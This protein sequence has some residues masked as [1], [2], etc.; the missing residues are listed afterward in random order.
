L[1]TPN[2]GSRRIA[3]A[4]D[5]DQHPDI[6]PSTSKVPGT[7]PTVTRTSQPSQPS[8]VTAP[9]REQHLPDSRPAPAAKTSAA[10]VFALVFGLAALFCALTAILSPAAILFGII[11][12]ILAV[13]G[14]KMAKRPGITGKSV[15][16][17]GLVTA[18]LGLILGGVVIGGLTAIV[19]NKSQLDRVQ[20]Y[21]DDA[22]AK[23][24]ST[25]QVRNS[26]PGQ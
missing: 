2:D 15:A 7:D 23:L 13:A 3:S 19:N 4:P 9:A 14:L 1:S 24:P 22:R 12:L 11:G 25:D 17:G 18:L 6:Y 8:T 16:V 10:A 21:I 20:S 5:P 26:V